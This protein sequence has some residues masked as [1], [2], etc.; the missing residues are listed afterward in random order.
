MADFRVLQVKVHYEGLKSKHDEW[1]A[2]A[3]VER[4]RPA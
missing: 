2:H 3:D 1:I 4:F